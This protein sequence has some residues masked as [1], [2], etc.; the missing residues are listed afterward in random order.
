MRI[1]FL[2]LLFSLACLICAKTFAIDE[3]NPHA[4]M[5][6]ERHT[7]CSECHANDPNTVVSYLDVRLKRGVTASCLRGEEGLGG[8]QCHSPGKLG[9]THPVDVEPGRD[10]EVPEDLHL[11][12]TMRI[13]CATC[14]NPHGSWTSPVPMV[15]RATQL[16]GSNLYR[17]YFLRRTNVRSVLCFACHLDK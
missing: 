12:E 9:R 4:F 6:D 2:S 3:A 17:S 15:A 8:I 5:N 11:D 16:A 1:I 14:H 10:M 7:L 13:T